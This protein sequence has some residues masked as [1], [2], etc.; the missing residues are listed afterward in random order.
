MIASCPVPS[1][2]GEPEHGQPD[3]QVKRAKTTRCN[4]H[5]RA[6][7]TE[8]PVSR[9][10]NDAACS[11]RLSIHSTF[12]FRRDSSTSSV[13]SPGMAKGAINL[14]TLREFNPSRHHP[15]PRVLPEFLSNGAKVRPS[16]SSIARCSRGRWFH[17][18]DQPGRQQQRQPERM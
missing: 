18:Q 9:R 13:S 12:E 8:P 2:S 7:V 11:W 15:A 16:I 4:V 17:A 10:V 14:V 3:R 6:A 1:T 5:T